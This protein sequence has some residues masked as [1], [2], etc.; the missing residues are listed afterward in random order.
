[1]E[2]D[3]SECRGLAHLEVTSTGGDCM[4][5]AAWGGARSHGI[6]RRR[7]RLVPALVHGRARALARP[8]VSIGLG[9]RRKFTAWSF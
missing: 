2:D 5:A 3:A 9:Q 1:M 7:R 4:T 8:L 6:R